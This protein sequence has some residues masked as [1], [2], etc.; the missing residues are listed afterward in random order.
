MTRLLG[1]ITAAA[2]IL[3]LCVACTPKENGETEEKISIVATIFP[4]Y[5]WVRQIIGTKS[6]NFVLTLLI[7]NS[8]DMHSYQPSVPDVAKITGCDLFIYI[9]GHSDVWVNDVLA[10]SRN[11]DMQVINMV[12]SLGD[13]VLMVEH[14]CGDEECTDDHHDEFEEIEEEHVWTSLRFAKLLSGIIAEQIIALDPDNAD[15][16]NSNL[17]AYTEKLDALDARYTEMTEQADNK[18]VVFADRFPFLYMMKDYGIEHHSAFAGCSAEAE[19]G[20]D[21]VTRLFRIVDQ[22]ELSFIMLTE[23]GHPGV[24]EQIIRE[25]RAKNQKILVLD[26]MKA[27]NASDIQNSVTYLSI[28]EKNLEVLRE[29]LS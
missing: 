17:S 18:I 6:D 14:D 5:D 11:S 8:V 19:A 2:V 16:Y 4:Q 28:M 7:D 20:W 22:H 9:G 25:T 21:V 24:A 12:K 26:G 27:V 3:T 15:Y 10:Q 29:A 13:K 1:I 23:T